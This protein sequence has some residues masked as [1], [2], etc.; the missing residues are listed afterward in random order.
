MIKL[1]APFRRQVKSEE[2]VFGCPIARVVR[3]QW[4][5]FYVKITEQEWNSRLPCKVKTR[6]HGEKGSFPVLTCGGAGL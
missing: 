1:A 3:D 2:R 4:C 6:S 5:H